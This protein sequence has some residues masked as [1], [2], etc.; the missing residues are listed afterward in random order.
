MLQRSAPQPPA[1]GVVY[2][3]ARPA[4]AMHAA[5]V[6]HETRSQSGSRLWI[7]GA[8]ILALLLGAAIVLLRMVQT[9][10]LLSF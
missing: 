2:P 6:A 5:P 4:S 3:T 7:V 1:I 8:I 9:G 10:A